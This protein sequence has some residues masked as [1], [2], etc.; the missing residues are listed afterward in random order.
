M[1]QLTDASVRDIIRSEVHS[2]VGDVR[3]ELSRID[4]HIQD[5][6]VI[7]A[8][9]QRAVRDMEQLLA[10]TKNLTKLSGLLSQLQLSIDDI[11]IRAKRS[12]ETSRYTAGYVAMRLRERYDKK[13]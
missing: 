11:R 9:V 12:E 2:A 10:Q 8:D 13:Y 1:G 3:R 6:R 7:Q 4:N 5:L